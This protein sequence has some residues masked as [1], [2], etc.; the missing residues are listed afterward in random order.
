[1]PRP[2]TAY[3]QWIHSVKRAID[4]DQSLPIPE[5]SPVL[6]PQQRDLWQTHVRQRIHN[7]TPVTP[8]QWLQLQQSRQS[9]QTTTQVWG[10]VLT[11]RLAQ[12]AGES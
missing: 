4:Q 1:M 8:Y 3:E 5:G 7:E 12:Q 2:M 6:T 11:H 10:D 9:T